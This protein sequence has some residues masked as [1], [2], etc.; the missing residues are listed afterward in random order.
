MLTLTSVR[1]QLL[2]AVQFKNDH[3][4]PNAPSSL[5][6]WFRALMKGDVCRRR[7]RAF[8]A[9][10]EETEEGKKRDGT[11]ERTGGGTV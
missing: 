6:V 1:K 7:R 3:P 4:A 2:L 9:Q 8:L 5:P 11:E 10:S